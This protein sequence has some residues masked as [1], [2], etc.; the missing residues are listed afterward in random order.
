MEDIEKDKYDLGTAADIADSAGE[1]E[2]AH[3]EGEGERKNPDDVPDVLA[4]GE[5]ILKDKEDEIF[6]IKKKRGSAGLWIAAAIPVL[7]V[8][9]VFGYR[10]M[11]RPIFSGQVPDVSPSGSGSDVEVMSTSETEPSVVSEGQPEK[12]A[13]YDADVEAAAPEYRP[14]NFPVNDLPYFIYVEKG[15]HTMTIYEKDSNGKYTIPVHTW[16]T[17]T[18]KG[19][20]M[21]KAGTYTIGEK[22]KWKEWGQSLYSPYASCFA[23][24]LYIHGPVY[25]G[26]R[27]Q[28]IEMW[29]F[30]GIGTNATSGCLRT[31]VEAAF[32]VYTNCDEGTGIKIVTGSPLN[33]SAEPFTL[34]DQLVSP[35]GDP[36]PPPV[37]RPPGKPTEPGGG[38]DNDDDDVDN[39][40]PSD[41]PPSD[42]G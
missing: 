13:P 12:T 22:L 32:F 10:F 4:G 16:Q 17:A 21:T 38:T 11:G 3:D 40:P 6:S 41:P 31:G 23:G 15:S 14:E 35:E 34:E 29:S 18:G 20:E 1:T 7:V 25:L 39:P 33:R 42:D 8:L 36:D 24:G 26:M 30:E 9:L 19:H 37:K 5:D 28:S 2:A 27:F